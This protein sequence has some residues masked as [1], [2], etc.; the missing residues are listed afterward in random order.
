MTASLGNGGLRWAAVTEATIRIGLRT[1][2]C[3]GVLI[4]PDLQHSP[5]TRTRFALTCAHYFHTGRIGVGVSG[6]SFHT[7]LE[8][9]RKVPWSDLAVV[10]LAKAAP[11]HDLPG[12]ANYRAP[13]LSRA[14]TH[15]FGKIPK[16]TRSA[17]KPGRII[18]RVPFALSRELK[19]FVRSG[20]V[21]YNNP[22]AIP[23]DSGGP[24]M[25]G[26]TVVA[27]QSLILNPFGRNLRIAT[28]SQ[29]AP[30]LP[31]IRRA[32]AELS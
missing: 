29:V 8:D 1:G 14:T 15:G 21:V 28:A 32:L 17:E 18:G 25:V 16:S 13:W 22:P 26:E 20:A 27:L 19:T 3:S 23:G 9:V 31:A 12:I 6:R 30:H 2:Y 10:R 4:S 5:A 7:T 11:V 24:V